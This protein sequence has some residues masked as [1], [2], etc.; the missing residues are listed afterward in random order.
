MLKDVVMD[1]GGSSGLDKELAMELHL[2]IVDLG[3]KMHGDRIIEVS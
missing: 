3:L 2:E 1:A